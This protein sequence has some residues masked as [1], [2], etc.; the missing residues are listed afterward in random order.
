M[1]GLLP[2]VGNGIGGRHGQQAKPEGGSQPQ[3]VL[4]GLQPHQLAK[5]G[6]GAGIPKDGGVQR[7]G[8]ALDL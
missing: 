4:V 6:D 1:R 3:G 7:L 5:A 8:V 2:G